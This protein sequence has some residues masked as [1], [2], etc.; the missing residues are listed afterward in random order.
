MKTSFRALPFAFGTYALTIAKQI[1]A[2]DEAQ[3]YTD[4]VVSEIFGPTLHIVCR[5]NG[6]L[7][8]VE[9]IG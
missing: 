3:R 9:C 1:H 7:F 8:H 2:C 6:Y 5:S 4:S